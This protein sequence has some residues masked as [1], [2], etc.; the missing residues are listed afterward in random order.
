MLAKVFA[1]L[2]DHSA[3]CGFAKYGTYVR[4]AMRH[5]AHRGQQGQESASA[6]GK[7]RA[8]RRSWC[9]NSCFLSARTSSSLGYTLGHTRR[10]RRRAVGCSTHG[11]EGAIRFFSRPTARCPVHRQLPP[12]FLYSAAASWIL[13]CCTMPAPVSRRRPLE[14]VVVN[15]HLSPPISRNSFVL[16][17][18]LCARL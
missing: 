9:T 17:A 8:R 18:A 5:A 1:K 15:S 13:A 12:S 7:S 14:V 3:T 2:S 10:S 11:N 6:R 4:W 16:S